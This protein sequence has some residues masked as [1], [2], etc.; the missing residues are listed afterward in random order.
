MFVPSDDRQRNEQRVQRG[1]S[2][3]VLRALVPSVVLLATCFVPPLR[4]GVLG[5]VDLVAR[6]FARSITNSIES[7]PPTTSTSVP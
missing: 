5:A 4:A 2:P 3:S 7:V 1:S 6:A